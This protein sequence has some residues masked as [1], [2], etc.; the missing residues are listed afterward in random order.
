MTGHFGSVPYFCHAA[1]DRSEPRRRL[2]PRLRAPRQHRGHDALIA[3]LFH[4]PYP[5]S[6]TA[7]FRRA[8]RRRA[9]AAW[10][11]IS[12]TGLLPDPTSQK[13]RLYFGQA[14]AQVDDAP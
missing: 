11:E 1:Q 3:N 4:I 12:Q 6:A 9:F 14:F 2:W 8:S 10:R 7:D 13:N 5:K